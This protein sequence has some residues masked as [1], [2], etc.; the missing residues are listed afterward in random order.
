LIPLAILSTYF[1]FQFNI[2]MKE[3][4][5]SL[6]R[7]LAESQRITFDLFLQER[8]VNLFHL[9]HSNAMQLPPTA[10]EMNCYLQ[11]LRESSDA[12]VDVG[13][14]NP[15]GKQI[16]YAGPYPSLRGRD[17]SN[18]KWFRALKTQERDYHITDIYL[19]FRNKPHFTLALRLSEGDDSGVIRATL[20]PDKLYMFLRTLNLG[21]GV[22]T[23]LVNLEG[24]YQLVDPGMGK[25]LEK[26]DFV[27]SSSERSG[28]REVADGR[29]THLVAY[30]WLEEVPWA[31]IVRQPLRVAYAKMY[32]A[33]RIM[34]LG[35]VVLL[36]IILA[37]VWL[38]TERLLRRAEATEAA[39]AS[40]KS[41][42]I[43]AGKLASLGELAAGIAH[44]INNPLAIVSSESGLI[45][46]M[47]DPRFGMDSAPEKIREE[48]DHIDEAVQR[49][50]NITKKLLSFSRK[51]QS[52]FVPSNLNHVLDEVVGGLKEEELRIADV[53]LVRDYDPNLPELLIDPDPLRQVFL[54]LINNAQDAIQ[55]SG[56]I[57][58]STHHDD[59]AARVTVRDTGKGMT[60]EQMER[61][62]L[63]FY[64]TKEVGKGT[65]LGL[66]ISSSLVESMGGRIEVQSLPGAGS[67]FTV[68][69]P[70]TK[71]G[72]GASNGGIRE[73]ERK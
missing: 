59:K 21:E 67:S 4:G 26:A 57:T 22:E 53:E 47:L 37:V 15:S 32:R 58:L 65:G 51:E 29:D 33:R 43:H 66:S 60:A 2:T 38:T 10:E 41:Q 13:F 34:I 8:L 11:D 9:L 17:Y 56:K 40:L 70:I 16:G 5:Q 44:E 36:M 12:F 39:R 68:V 19:G 46:D 27:P 49:A 7:T 30:A 42:L 61:I 50:T 54:N 31:L 3:R 72:E 24:R 71:Q 35:T 48:L 62:F 23:G 14:L 25:L 52:R 20:D 6:L 18:E 64:T 63:P 1:H 69:L 55:G 45:R 73:S 28:F